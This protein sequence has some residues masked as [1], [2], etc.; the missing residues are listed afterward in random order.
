METSRV[1]SGSRHSAASSSSR[2][3][4]TCVWAR[5]FAMLFAL[6]CIICITLIF[7]QIWMVTETFELNR[8]MHNLENAT[9][10]FKELFGFWFNKTRCKSQKKGE[11][12]P[13]D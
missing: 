2:I 4:E 10:N 1:D 7:L 8:T 9:G 5:E 3:S 6:L 13:R 11:G 12:G